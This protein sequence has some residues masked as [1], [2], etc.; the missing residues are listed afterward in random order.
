MLPISP[1]EA[2]L[3]WIVKFDKPS[4]I[5]RE[6]LAKQKA[7]GVKRKLIGFEV[8]GRGIGRD[9]YEIQINGHLQVG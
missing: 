2:G 1:L 7:D 4:F 6:A 5:G 8:T 3:G 9:G